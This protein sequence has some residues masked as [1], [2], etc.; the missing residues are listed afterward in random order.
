M[1][2]FTVL[3]CFVYSPLIMPPLS[4]HHWFVLLS[5]LCIGAY[6]NLSTCT[7]FDKKYGCILQRA[8]ASSQWQYQ[9]D[10]GRKSA[11][12]HKLTANAS[13]VTL[14]GDLHAARGKQHRVRTCSLMHF[15]GSL[16]GEMIQIFTTQQ[17]GSIKKLW[18]WTSPSRHGFVMN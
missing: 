16:K 13:G 7:Q 18:M 6:S 11:A 4:A 9:R 1:L 5:V 3:Y 10:A 2:T 17:K 12:W 8:P 14:I 15:S